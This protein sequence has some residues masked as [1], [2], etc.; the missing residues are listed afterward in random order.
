MDACDLSALPQDVFDL[1]IDKGAPARALCASHR[2]A[3]ALC[4]QP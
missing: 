2:A 4:A 1:V 3:D